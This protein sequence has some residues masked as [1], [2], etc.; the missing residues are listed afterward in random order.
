LKS[1]DQPAFP[2]VPKSTAPSRLA[3]SPE[4]S[5]RIFLIGFMG[6]GKSYTAHQL[7]D[8]LGMPAFDLDDRIESAEQRSI[9]AIFAE[10]GEAYFRQLEARQLRDLLSL[11]PAIV[12]T[13]GGTPCQHQ[14][15]DWMNEHGV[16]VFLDAAPDLLVQRLRGTEAQRPL[17]Q[18][19]SDLRRFID[20]KLAERRPVYEKAQIIVQQQTNEEPVAQR[21]F[22]NLAQLLGH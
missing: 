8:L 17:L 10:S 13:G 4:N 11:P 6:S 5:L 14:N 7:A 9:S 2:V 3:F 20:E 16:T 12:A 18:S 1:E 21:I 19:R 15:M 22:D